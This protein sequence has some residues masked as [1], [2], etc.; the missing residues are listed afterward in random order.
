MRIV[1]FGD[2]FIQRKT[3]VEHQYLSLVSGHFSKL[4]ESFG[5]PG[6]GVWDSF[7]EFKRVRNEADLKLIHD[8][9]VAI[10]VWSES[11]RFYHAEVRDITYANVLN[12]ENS[13]D[14]V[15]I[16]AKYYYE[17]LHD[18]RKVNY[19][20]TAFFYW[21]DNWLF[22]NYP[23]MKVI[24][25]TGFPKHD[26]KMSIDYYDIVKY[27]PNKLEYF[28]KWKNSVEVRPPLLHFSLN[29]EWPGDLGKEHRFQHLTKDAH[30]KVAQLIIEAI[31]NYEP[32]KIIEYVQPVEEKKEE[33]L[34]K[35]IKNLF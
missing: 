24:H 5:V 12:H 33:K 3:G 19:E 27:K 22:E 16:A 29:D 34:I 26:E 7:F 31:E 18:A 6:S 23:N 35:K 13:N 30:Y 21:F 32:G 28:H 8:F 1:G 20:I 2:S 25:L 10:F 11:S 17:H 15:W 9:D 14:P 4:F